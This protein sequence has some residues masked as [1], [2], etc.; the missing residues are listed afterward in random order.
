MTPGCSFTAIRSAPSSRPQAFA[1]GVPQRLGRDR[2]GEGFTE[3]FDL[4]LGAFD[5]EVDREIRVRDRSPDRVAVV[6][7]RDVADDAPFRPHRFLAYHDVRR[8]VER[9]AGETMRVAALEPLL[10]RGATLEVAL[11]HLHRE[12]E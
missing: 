6:R 5:G 12:A 3:V 2:R 8:I 10:E 7:R 9:H 4:E 11:V 1:L